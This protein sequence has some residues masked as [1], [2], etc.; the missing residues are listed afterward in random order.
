LN[1]Y[2]IMKKLLNWIKIPTNVKQ[3]F[4]EYGTAT[5]LI[6]VVVWFIINK[7]INNNN[8]EIKVQI[9][10]TNTAVSNIQNKI[11]SVLG[12]QS[13]LITRTAELEMAQQ[14]TNRMIERGNNLLLQNKLSLEKIRFDYNEKINGVNNYNF[15]DLDSFFTNRYPRY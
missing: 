9:E 2:G 7:N 6:A 4:I 1:I 13:F 10:V 14:E 15:R 12:Y 11:D 8:Q 5:I 3:N